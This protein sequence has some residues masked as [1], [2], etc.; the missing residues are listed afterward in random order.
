MQKILIVLLMTVCVS[1][2]AQTKSTSKKTVPAKKTTTTTTKA[3]APV[4]FKNQSDSFS[5]AIGVSIANFYRE[6]GITNVNSTMVTKA[7]NDCKA[8]KP[9]LDEGQVN[10]IIMGYMQQ[11]R[12]E[13]SAGA[14]SAGEAFLAENKKKPGVITT[15]SGLQ[16]IIIKQGTGPKPTA[17]DRVKVHY[18]GT[19]IDGTIFDSSVDRGEPA[20]LNL[21]EVIQGWIEG[22]SLM[23]TGSKW[24]LFI[25]ANLA[26]GDNDAGPIIKAGSAVIFDVELFEIV[27][28]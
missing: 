23:P 6:Q 5:Y 19:L 27:A 12:S 3:P 28:K 26:W 25:P 16:Y 8:G 4:K 22:I 21:P 20:V 1:S 17:T 11:K 10:S 2:Y 15:A 7:L 18:H 13:K 14:R 24:R 9:A